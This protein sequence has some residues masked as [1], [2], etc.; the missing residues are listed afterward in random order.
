MKKT[1][2]WHKA[3]KTKKSEPSHYIT[4]KAKHP[5]TWPAGRRTHYPVLV[6][7]G[8]V[9]S[10]QDRAYIIISPGSRFLHN[11]EPFDPKKANINE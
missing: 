5:H 3:K 10:N 7:C 2:I 8:T 11:L 4:K 1:M 6:T 9:H